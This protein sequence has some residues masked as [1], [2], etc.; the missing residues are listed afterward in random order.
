M[1][2]EVRV[3]PAVVADADAVLDLIEGLADY[4]QFDRPTAEARHRLVV[5]GFGPSPRFHVLLAEMGGRPVGYALFFHTY[6]SFRARPSLYLE[7]FF[8]VPDARGVGVGKSLFRA[9]ARRA[10]DDGCGR[11]EWV[12]LGWN[13]LAKDFYDAAGATPVDEWEFYRLEG[14]SLDRWG[15]S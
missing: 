3:R 9:V 4:E 1:S 7:D 14:E 13:Q 11:M 5:D 2:A 6:S 12:V 15:R 10:V 8:V